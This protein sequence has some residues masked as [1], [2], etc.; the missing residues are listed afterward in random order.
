MGWL[1]LFE[2]FS[3]GLLILIGLTNT[4]LTHRHPL[5]VLDRI[6]ALQQRNPNIRLHTMPHVGHWVHR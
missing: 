4:H 1:L 5:Q 2:F 3:C 6:A